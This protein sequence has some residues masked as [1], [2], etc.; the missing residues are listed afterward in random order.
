MKDSSIIVKLE[1]VNRGKFNIVNFIKIHNVLSVTQGI[2]DLEHQVQIVSQ[3]VSKL[4]KICLALK[5]DGIV[6]H[7]NVRLVLW[8]INFWLLL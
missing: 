5:L 1:N 8:K 3:N 6:L 2:G 4:M 7:L